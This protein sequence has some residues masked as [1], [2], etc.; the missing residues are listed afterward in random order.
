MNS[1]PCQN[2]DRTFFVNV[3]ILWCFSIYVVHTI[4]RALKDIPKPFMKT[5]HNVDITRAK[6]YDNTIAMNAMFNYRVYV[7]TVKT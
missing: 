2:Y 5:K 7:R 3:A 1:N 6:G 4:T